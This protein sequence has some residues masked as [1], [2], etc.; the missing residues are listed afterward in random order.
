MTVVHGRLNVAQATA[1]AASFG[2]RDARGRLAIVQKR[3]TAAATI[4]GMDSFAQLLNGV[5]GTGPPITETVDEILRRA[6]QKAQKQKAQN[7]INA[8]A[9]TAADQAIAKAVTTTMATLK[10]ATKSTNA[11]LV[12]ER[13]KAE[14]A[15]EG[16]LGGA[17]V[18]GA[19]KA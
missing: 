12:V 8:M 14:R 5:A 10:A 3:L 13:K 17:T 7:Q 15:A 9:R 2:V 16:T 4:C 18:G 19:T 11:T 1:E 6:N